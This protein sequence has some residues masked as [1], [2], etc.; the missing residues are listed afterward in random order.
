MLRTGQES[1]VFLL[2]NAEDG[3][4]EA[5]AWK[6]PG[7]G[8]PATEVIS[9]D[10]RPPEH[11]ETPVLRIRMNTSAPPRAVLVLAAGVLAVAAWRVWPM[12][13]RQGP[14]LALELKSRADELTALW[15]ERGG[16]DRAVKSATLVLE[17]WTKGQTMDLTRNF[18]PRGQ[19]TLRPKGRDVVVTLTVEYKDGLRVSRGATYSGFPSNTAAPTEAELKLLHKQNQQLR[20]AL[21]ELKKHVSQ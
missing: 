3:G 20:E 13:E 11:W 2:G 4:V 7:N 8:E 18:P 9:L 19:V 14:D 21:D 16:G 1:N 12:P 17:D 15:T 10:S 6:Q 5:T